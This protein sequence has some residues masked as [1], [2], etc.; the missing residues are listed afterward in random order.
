MDRYA[1]ATLRLGSAGAARPVRFSRRAFAARAPEDAAPGAVLATLLTEPRG[2]VSGPP[3]AAEPLPTT[4]RV[5]I[6]TN[7][8]GAFSPMAAL[9][10]YNKYK[11]SGGTMYIR[12]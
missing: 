9:Q 3:P 7:T 5:A 6:K 11:L 1:L 10:A 4:P 2:A 12:I 8:F